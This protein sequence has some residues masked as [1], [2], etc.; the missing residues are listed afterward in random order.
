MPDDLHIRAAIL[1]QIQVSR[2]RRSNAGLDES[3]NSGEAA[4]VRAEIQELRNR[5]R[6]M[7]NRELRKFGTAARLKCSELT[8]D[9]ASREEFAIQFE[10]AKS[11]YA[12]RHTRR[13]PGRLLR[14]KRNGRKSG[15]KEAE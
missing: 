6:A 8:L 3:G 15:Q 7:S 13:Y 14:R 11:E 1:S 9:D 2:N 5:L 12:R 4:P 10:E